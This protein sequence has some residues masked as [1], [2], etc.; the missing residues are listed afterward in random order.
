MFWHQ[1]ALV[2][3]LLLCLADLFFQ[4][5]HCTPGGPALSY[6]DSVTR[7]DSLAIRSP[8][9]PPSGT[10]L[11]P[12]I[13]DPQDILVWST[14][15][16]WGP[17]VQVK[18]NPQAVVSDA[19]LSDR[20]PP[21]DPGMSDGTAGGAQGQEGLIIPEPTG[22]GNL[23]YFVPGSPIRPRLT[24]SSLLEAALT[25]A[26]LQK[27]PFSIKQAVA[28]PSF[29]DGK[30]AYTSRKVSRL[31]SI[32]AVTGRVLQTFG[33]DEAPRYPNLAD[34]V[35]PSIMLSRTEY[36]LI[37]SDRE[38]RR[39]RW[40]ITFGEYASAMLPDSLFGDEHFAPIPPT[41]PSIAASGNSPISVTSS[42]DGVVVIDQKSEEHPWALKFEAPAVSAFDVQ[43]A[44]SG[45]G[46]QVAQVFPNPN[47]PTPRPQKDMDSSD[48]FVGAINNTIYALSKKYSKLEDV[49]RLSISDSSQD[50]SIP[51]EVSEESD[52]V[53]VGEKG[54]SV[55]TELPCAPGSRRFPA[56]LIG[57]HKVAPSPKPPGRP[58]NGRARGGIITKIIGYT[59]DRF[60]GIEEILGVS[61]EDEM[62]LL[63]LVALSAFVVVLTAVWMQW[64]GRLEA[65]L[66]ALRSRAAGRQGED[67]SV[68]LLPE[69]DPTSKEEADVAVTDEAADDAYN[70]ESNETSPNK[71]ASK[72]KGKTKVVKLSKDASKDSSDVDIDVEAGIIEAEA[73]ETK[74]GSGPDEPGSLKTMV[75][76]DTILGHGS[77][78]TMVFKGTFGSREV[79]VKRLLLDFY[80]IAHH[81]VQMLRDSDHHPNVIRYFYQEAT[82]KFMYIA[83]ELCPASLHDVIENPH[84]ARLGQL[85]TQ[86]NPRQTLSQIIAGIQHLHSMKIVHRDIK[87]QNILIAENDKK[88][89]THPR[90]LIS[91]FGLCKRLAD[92]QSS[93]HNT[94]NSL[95][96]TLGWRAR[97]C[98]LGGTTKDEE[99]PLDEPSSES[100][101]SN[102]VVL[103]PNIQ[104]RITRAVDIF[105]AGCVFYYFLTGGSHPFGDRYSREN[106]ILKGNHRVDKLD[107]IAD[108]GMEASH[109]IKRMI[110]KDPKKRPTAASVSLH[111]YFWTATK[112]LNFLQDSSD[113]FEV[114]DRDPPSGIMKQL[115]RGGSNV[116]G[117]DWSRKID[118]NLLDNLGK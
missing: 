34:A 83:L 47:A 62:R 20:I 39:V 89:Q 2:I 25:P 46:H 9:Q 102:W 93:F 82:E 70:T 10:P 113:R 50:D 96:G 103:A 23:Y 19:G 86:L 60:K 84:S 59:L 87:P 65:Q 61:E 57:T 32:D 112:K 105:S 13:F 110:S 115:E 97:E 49:S 75:V 4:H 42:V 114:E 91:D 94:V 77:H 56:C 104:V 48:V 52:V 31:Y 21:F 40:N 37:I 43:N 38:T 68:P 55:V 11:G 18:E 54:L 74:V 26:P 33:D 24:V 80:D 76:S 30:V 45:D 28:G 17:L 85:R 3:G 95:G 106:N 100:E 8:P 67:A 36:I 78:G 64:K 88:T 7:P 98:M 92:D 69:H 116:V 6:V 44:P 73:G 14:K 58:H 66:R 90:I 117:S 41:D 72:K 53:E 107:S 101:P 1:N 118:R 108:G 5:V 81:E 71:K 51:K 99:K 12:V 111:P 22:D 109:L 16:S 27:L 63:S 79:A 15:D 35:N 29:T